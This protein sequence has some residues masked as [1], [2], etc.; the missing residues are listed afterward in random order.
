MTKLVEKKKLQLSDMNLNDFINKAYT[1]RG[2]YGN[3]VSVSTHYDHEIIE[4]DDGEYYVDGVLLESNFSDLEEVKRHIELEQSVSNVKSTLYED[5]SDTK[6]A[7]IIGKHSNARITTTLVES[8]MNLASSKTF[9]VD[10]VLLEMRTQYRNGN[11]IDNKIDFK[12]NDGKTVAV[13][14]ETVVKIARLLNNTAHKEEVITYMRENVNTFMHV[15][16]NL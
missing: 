7:H 16:K 3:V 5:I 4:N 15:V 9:D 11:L 2:N 6:V 8:Y 12:L 10:P 14:E 13:S 1:N